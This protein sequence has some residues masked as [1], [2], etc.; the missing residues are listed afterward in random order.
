MQVML[1]G[2]ISPVVLGG[3]LNREACEAHVERVLVPAPA[4]A[5]S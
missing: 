4:R 1:R 3:A 2:V 5:R